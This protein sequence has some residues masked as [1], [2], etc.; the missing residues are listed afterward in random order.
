MTPRVVFVRVEDSMETIRDTMEVHGVR[1][2]P[3]VDNDR[4][5]G[6]VSRSDV[7]GFAESQYRTSRVNRAIGDSRMEE[8]FVASV[9]TREVVT[10]RADTPLADAAELLL[11]RRVGCLPVVTAEGSLCGIV[12]QHDFVKAFAETL[13]KAS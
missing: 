5:V 12:T 4:V 13:R 1:H 3:V 11:E 10:V 7:L 9:M 8:T 6:V 2:I